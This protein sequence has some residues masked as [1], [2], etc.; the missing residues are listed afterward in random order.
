MA[1]A[2]ALQPL[3]LRRHRQKSHPRLHF[4]AHGCLFLA[5]LIKL[6][7]ASTCGAGVVPSRP[8]RPHCDSFLLPSCTS[9]EEPPSGQQVRGLGF[10]EALL[11]A[12]RRLPWLEVLDIGGRP[13]STAAAGGAAGAEPAAAAATVSALAGWRALRRLDASHLDLTSQQARPGSVLIVTYSRAPCAGDAAA[14]GA[15][16]CCGVGC[17]VF[18][19]II[20]QHRCSEVRMTVLRNVQEKHTSCR[21]RSCWAACRPW[22]RYACA[23]AQAR[24]RK[25]SPASASD[26]RASTF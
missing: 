25:R 15:A 5:V 22:R 7:N 4:P 16:A 18:H 26:S 21:S 6:A 19:L 13:G 3:A 14:V 9:L 20:A 12:L 1:F 8:I 10:A 17:A 11:A 2:R 23:A 24:G